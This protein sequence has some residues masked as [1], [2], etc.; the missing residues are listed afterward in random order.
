MIE[1]LYNIY[2]E[3]PV[4][5]TDSR[6]CPKDSIFFALKGAMFDGNDYAVQALEKGCS[7]AVVDNSDGIAIANNCKAGFILEFLGFAAVLDCFLGVHGN[8]FAIGTYVHGGFGF[9]EAHGTF[10]GVVTIFGI[11]F[12]YEVE[13]F[14]GSDFFVAT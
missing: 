9:D 2:Q 10:G 5:T 8:P 1:R 11:Q 7:F 14:V 6:N 13:V 4:V 12:C 3:H